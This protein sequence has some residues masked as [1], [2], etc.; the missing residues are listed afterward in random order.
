[1]ALPKN[2][3]RNDSGPGAPVEGG[4]DLALALGN[5]VQNQTQEMVLA[6]TAAQIS[7]HQA[8]DQ[9]SD[10]FARVASGQE[11]LNETL[12][13]TQEKLEAMGGP[14]IIDTTVQPIVLN[15]PQSRDYGQTVSGFR[16]LFAPK[17][18]IPAHY[19]LSAPTAADEVSSDD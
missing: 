6:A 11:L 17:H 10:Y 15:L 19:I 18:D 14:V 8:A 1:M 12:A 3:P 5:S 13:M 16:G 7:I 9:L 4:G 2:Q